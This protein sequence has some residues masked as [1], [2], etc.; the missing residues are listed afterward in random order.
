MARY[1]LASAD[2]EM[3]LVRRD[4]AQI[5]CLRVRLG[6]CVCDNDTWN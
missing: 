2:N 5:G 1:R 4:A 3:S 6:V